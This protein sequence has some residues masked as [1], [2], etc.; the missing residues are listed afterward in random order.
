VRDAAHGVRRL[1]ASSGVD[2]ASALLAL[3]EDSPAA[4]ILGP[5]S[6]RNRGPAS[7]S[8]EETASWFETLR[9]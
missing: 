1:M 8:A 7:G 3:P 2:N 5:P 4:R 6:P 9:Q